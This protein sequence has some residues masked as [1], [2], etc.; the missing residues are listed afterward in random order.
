MISFDVNEL[1]QFNLRVACL[2]VKDN[3]VLFQQ[4]NN[5]DYWF[6]PGGRVEAMEETSATVDREINEEYGWKVK[7]KRLVWIVENFFRLQ[8]TDYHELG[9]YYLVEIEGALNVTD[10]HFSCLEGISVSRWIPIQ[11]FAQHPI[12]PAFL[13]Q[14]TD[15]EQ[16]MFTNEVKHII[17]RG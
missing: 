12:V 7:A 15:L 16:L 13:K 3:C 9:L 17:N 8:G 10:E 2:I 1:Q 5:E 6:L 14:A 4:F 11:A